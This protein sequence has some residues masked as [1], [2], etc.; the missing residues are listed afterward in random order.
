MSVRVQPY[1]FAL[2]IFLASVMARLQL[3][4]VLPGRVPYITFFPAVAA[5]AYF[6]GLGP[7]LLVLALVVP[8]SWLVWE[9]QSIALKLFG[10]AVFATFAGAVLFIIERLHQTLRTLEAR[11]RKLQVINREQQ[12]RIKN[13]FAVTASICI[14]TV[15]RG[16]PV[17][18]TVEAITG[19]IGSIAAAQD[20]LSATANAGADL[21]ALLGALVKPLAPVPDRLRLDGPHV[22][23]RA[24]DS[25]PMALVLYE[26]GTN[27]LKYG[28]WAGP[29]GTVSVSWSRNDQA[30]VT[31][32]WTECDGPPPSTDPRPG[33]GTKLIR[34]ALPDADVHF[35]LKTTGLEVRITLPCLA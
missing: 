13:L 21:E 16:L 22:R 23:L 15:R 35:D 2:A 19:R 34:Q 24:Q 5:T 29:A 6:C 14:Q 4:M 26:L 1:V 18:D 11:D 3:D 7:A 8:T 10:T 31:L 9:E 12:H 27:A 32:I 20:L 28:A 17:A 30:G 25:T 33:L